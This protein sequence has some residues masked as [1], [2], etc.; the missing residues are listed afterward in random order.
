[1][2]GITVGDKKDTFVDDHVEAVAPVEEAGTCPPQPPSPTLASLGPG[3]ATAAVTAALAPSAGAATEGVARK[4]SWPK[5]RRVAPHVEAEAPEFFDS[6]SEASTDP[7]VDHVESDAAEVEDGTDLSQCSD[8]GADALLDCAK[9]AFWD[10]IETT[11]AQTW[12]DDW[13][14]WWRLDALE[15]TFLALCA[16]DD[17]DTEVCYRF[18]DAAKYDRGPADVASG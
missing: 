16:T 15:Q 13:D 5:R 6:A 8:E 9:S 3:T 14:T 4:A 7:L 17:F 1:M 2:E 18:V 12:P 11:R 10:T